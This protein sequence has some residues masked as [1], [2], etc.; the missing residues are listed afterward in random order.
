MAELFLDF[1]F[2]CLIVVMS[3]LTFT[4]CILTYNMIKEAL[5]K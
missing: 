5:K 1:F 4:M 2:G 3:T